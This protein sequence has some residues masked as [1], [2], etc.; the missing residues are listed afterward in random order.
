MRITW[1]DVLIALLFITIG[2]LFWWAISENR[3]NTLKDK[4]IRR[5]TNENDEIRKGYLDL[6]Q[7]FLILKGETAPDILEEL[8][9]LKESLSTL[10]KDAHIALGNVIGLVND[11]YYETAV[12]D[13][14]KIIENIL[15]EKID[16]DASFKKKRD[17]FNF[18]QHAK[19]CKWIKPHE[20]A[21]ADLIR[22]MRNNDSHEWNVKEEP[23]KIG[24]AIFA[25]IEIV[26]SLTIQDAI[27][28]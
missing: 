8:E 6:L 14:A 4:I 25:G 9:K 13:L 24:L 26:Y 3:K 21:Y 15:K 12:R 27:V 10:N 2:A 1:K 17:L 5:L 23:H 18:L 22:L 7:R 19:E 20:H 16:V 28:V 11:G